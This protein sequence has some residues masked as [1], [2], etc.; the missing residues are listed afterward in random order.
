MGWPQRV[1]HERVKKIIKNFAEKSFSVFKGAKYS[2]FEHSKTFFGEI[3]NNL[4]YMFMKNQTRP[5]QF[6]FKDKLA[7]VIK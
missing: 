3:F 2:K 5:P 1:F 7:H 4:F 6:F